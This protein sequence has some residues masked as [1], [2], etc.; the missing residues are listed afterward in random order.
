VERGHLIRGL[1]ALLVIS[2]VV[3]VAAAAGA[4]AFHWSIVA[5]G[6]TEANAAPTSVGY[7]A[8]TRTQEARFAGRL[9]SHDRD[10]LRGVDLTTTGVVAVFL[11]GIPCGSKARVDQVARTAS[12]L[13]VEVSYVPPPLGVGTCVRV[14]TPY[15]V[16]GVARRALGRPA[17]SRVRVVAV[18]RT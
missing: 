12:T 16:V 2:A 7:L 1:A 6:A 18:A 11:Y 9:S 17:P 10:V 15:F 8:V 13:N 4:T 14:S 3:P 5:E